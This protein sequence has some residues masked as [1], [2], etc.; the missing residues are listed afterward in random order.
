MSKS[1]NDADSATQDGR[2]DICRNV[3]YACTDCV[4]LQKA[5]EKSKKDGENAAKCLPGNGANPVL[6]QD[7][8]CDNYRGVMYA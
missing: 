2:C 8:R 4:N 7:G 5:I 3:M 1:K 6:A